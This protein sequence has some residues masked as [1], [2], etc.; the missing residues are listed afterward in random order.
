[1]AVENQG[2]ALGLHVFLA[3]VVAVSLAG[4]V[5][6]FRESPE[7]VL[8][9]A[10]Q[11]NVDFGEALPAPSYAGVAALRAAAEVA[12]LADQ[13]EP[14]ERSEV[15]EIDSAALEQARTTLGERRAFD[16]APPVIP[17]PVQED[18]TDCVACHADGLQ[19]ASFRAPQISHTIY[20]SC[21]QCHVSADPNLPVVSEQILAANSFSGLAAGPDRG[22]VT[23]PPWPTAPPVIP[24]STMMRQRCASCHGEGGFPALR[25][26]HPERVSCTQ[27]HVPSADLDLREAMPAPFPIISW[28]APANR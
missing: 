13:I 3:I 25:T 17:H 19:G 9:P 27:C 2:S 12:P 26:P 11:T 24:H 22:A 8:P 6:G 4:L 21:T 5:Y 14:F 15:A 23:A 28:N 1:M 16:G 7:P 18:S 10:Q 20:A